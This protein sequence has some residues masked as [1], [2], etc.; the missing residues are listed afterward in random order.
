MVVPPYTKW[1][2]LPKNTNAHLEVL[3]QEPTASHTSL[4]IVLETSAEVQL[5]YPQVGSCLDGATEVE[6][7]CQIS[8]AITIIFQG[9]QG[10]LSYIAPFFLDTLEAPGEGAGE[11]GGTNW[12]ILHVQWICGHNTCSHSA[13]GWAHPA[14]DRLSHP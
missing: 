10:M 3:W 12:Q 14:R 4:F 8:R 1:K 6:D 7:G 5:V 11:A 9:L 13:N 2:G